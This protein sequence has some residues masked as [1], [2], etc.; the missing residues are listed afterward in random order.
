MSHFL[1]LRLQIEEIILIRL[2]YD[3]HSFYYLKSIG[4]QSDGF[5]RIITKEP[6]IMKSKVGHNLGADTV[7]TLIRRKAK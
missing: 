5:F 7:V 6:D 4:L 3:R 1:L 2:T